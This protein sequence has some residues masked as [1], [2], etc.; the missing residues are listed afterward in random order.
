M[1]KAHGINTVP[2]KTTANWFTRFQSDNFVV[3]VHHSLVNQLLKKSMKS[4]NTEKD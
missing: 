2:K 1:L 4:V 3:V